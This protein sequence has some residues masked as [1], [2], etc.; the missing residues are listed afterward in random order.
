VIES[1]L[2]YRHI[3][4][5]L[6]GLSADASREKF[7][8]RLGPRLLR[9]LAPAMG[10]VAVHAYTDSEGGVRLLER[11]G[12]GRSDLARELG[13]RMR[14][15]G[16]RGI[17]DFPWAGE[18][19]AGRAGLARIEDG[20][21]PLIAVFCA[22]PG[23]LRPVPSRA[24]LASAM[25]SLQYAVRQHL[26]R[27]E[28]ENAMDQ[29]RIIQLSL[30]PDGRPS[31]G[32][33]DIAAVSV[34]ATSVGGDLYDFIPLQEDMLALAVADA[35]GHGLPAALQARDVVTGLRMGVERDLKISRTVEK[36][37]RVIHRSGLVTRFVSMVFGELERNGNFAY[38]NAGHPPPQ[39]L[40]GDG[41]RELSVGGMVLG[42]YPDATYKVGF[43]HVDRGASL[44]LY[45]DGVLERG[46]QTGE[47]FELER[48]RQWMLD[49]R[50]GPAD[51]AVPDLLD[52]L[53]AYGDGGPFEDDVT[54][55]L[56]RRPR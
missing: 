17:H 20:G 50:D 48:V 32:E 6:I 40:D 54:V 31:F 22:T 27:G 8:R 55:M 56:V 18:T 37:N 3:E 29:A 13:E 12:E 19:G 9:D 34:P 24:D 36:L 5:T 7:V 49:W 33:F 53:R 26:H 52:R 46:T 38:I 42:P 45:S 11:W 43:A 16:E 28:L 1:K 44:A 14:T 4:R 30:L 21:G 39:L 15:A 41:F 25:A 51:R 23:D 2:F 47:A 10:I 35:S